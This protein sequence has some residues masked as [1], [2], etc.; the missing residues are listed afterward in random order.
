MKSLGLVSGLEMC[1]LSGKSCQLSE[2]NSALEILGPTLKGGA[3]DV[4]E[5]RAALLG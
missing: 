5:L 1:N 2:R 4:E 3:E